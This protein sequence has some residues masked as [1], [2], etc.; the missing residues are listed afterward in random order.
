LKTHRESGYNCAVQSA[1]RVATPPAKPLMIYDGDCNFCSLWVRR[2]QCASGER[3]EYLPYQDPQVAA[4]F[5]E[6]P[7]ERFTSAVHLIQ[8]DGTAFSAGEAVFRSLAFHPHQRW[9]LDLYQHSPMFARTTEWSYAFVARHR[10]W[11]S[12]LT[13]LLWGQHIEPPS[14]KLVRWFFLRSLGII[15]LVAFVSL[16]MQITGLVG[17]YG[18]VPAAITLKTVDQ[19]LTAAKIG[20]NRYHVFPTLCWFS[21]SDGFLKF[22]CAAGTL[23]AVLLILGIAPAP[24]LFL[25]WLIYLSLTTVGDVFLGFQWDNLLLETGFL[26]IFFA[27]F[28]WLPRRPSREAPP[29][30]VVLW[31]LRW[32]LFRLIFESGCVKLLSHDPTWRSLTALNFHYQTQPLPT[33]IGWYAGQ[34]PGWFQ[35]GSV[36]VIFGIEL[37]LPFLIFVPRRPRR[38]ACAAFTLLQLLIM[39]T[40]NYGFF[41]LLTITL[42][43]TLLDDAWLQKYIPAKWRNVSLNPQA[44]IPSTRRWPI[45][46][47]VPLTAI[48]LCASFVQFF[49]LLRVYI[50]GPGPVV[51]VYRWL[52][53][54]RT[55]NSYGLFAVMT[56]TRREI[57]VEGSNNG[58]SW[59]P[60]VFKYKPGDLR[61]RPGLVGTYMPRLDW[62]MWFAALGNYRQNPWFMN[63]CTRLLQGSPQVLALLE[64]NPF[65]NAPPRF[66]RAMIYEY[67]FTDNATRRKTGMWWRREFKGVYLRPTSL[68]AN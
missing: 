68:A 41:N 34:L 64:K 40:G 33:W 30:R 37:A 24:C 58:L 17:S 44:P 65:P 20:W 51:A 61:Q 35:K 14:F 28:Q 13:R 66:V 63:F 47:T 16:W 18:I 4:R 53:P 10:Q 3:V 56:T 7:R 50:P 15:Y 52:M 54:L 48:V 46:V 42:C 60:Y 5:P 9:L 25:L 19:Q 8:P 31:L 32:L 11:F 2:W 62:Q 67:H 57:I 39:L 1:I 49:G 21:A 26:A 23:L 43:L 45:Q 55:F 6:I 38:F 59:E 22:Q 36:L 29:S 27:P 12:L